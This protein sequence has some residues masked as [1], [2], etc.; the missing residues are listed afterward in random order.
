M[1]TLGQQE[2]HVGLVL[3]QAIQETSQMLSR[4]ITNVDLSD[5]K[6]CTQA[7]SRFTKAL[8]VLEST[9]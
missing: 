2:V 3:C 7:L 5:R 4:A 1:W 6:A 9:E 8:E